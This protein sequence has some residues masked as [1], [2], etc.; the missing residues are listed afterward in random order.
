LC[1]YISVN[2]KF[3]SFIEPLGTFNGE[4]YYPVI[5]KHEL[6]V[7]LYYQLIESIKNTFSS[8][9]RTKKIIFNK[10]NSELVIPSSIDIGETTVKVETPME[11]DCHNLKT[12]NVSVLGGQTLET[13]SILWMHI[14]VLLDCDIS[15]GQWDYNTHPI[16]LT[17]YLD[18]NKYMWQ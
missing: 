12:R 18:G 15:K 3:N 8:N 13:C 11:M 7:E 16:H 5:H 1:I 6:G 2:R 9:L 17:S 10:K 14:H 4:S